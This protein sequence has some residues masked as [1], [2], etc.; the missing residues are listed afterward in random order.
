[1]GDR[2]SCLMC[3]MYRKYSES[4]FCLVDIK[5]MASNSD[6]YRLDGTELH[7]WREMPESGRFYGRS[8]MDI[9]EEVEDVIRE[10]EK[11]KNPHDLDYYDYYKEE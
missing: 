6:K 10:Q 4:R 7:L 3:G 1:M 9:M 11:K 5:R 8:V 2:F